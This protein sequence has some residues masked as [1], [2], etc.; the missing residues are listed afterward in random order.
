MEKDI[1]KLNYEIE[2]EMWWFK[3]RKNIIEKLFVNNILPSKPQ[4]L[5][6]FGAGS[7]LIS[8]M[9][10][11]YTKVTAVDK[12]EETQKYNHF[13]ISLADLSDFPAAH[14]DVIT[15]FDSLEHCENDKDILK[16]FYRI[17]KPGG[18]VL[19][20]VPAF[21]SLWSYHDEIHHHF[22]RY[23]RNEIIN[24]FKE[25]SIVPLK[26]SYFNFFLFPVFV[27]G[28]LVTRLIRILSGKPMDTTNKTSFIN[29]IL[30]SIFNIEAKILAKCS[31]PWGSSLLFI[32]KKI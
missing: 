13:P 25:H 26:S 8:S 22:R 20:T 21:Q 6:D 31:L 15:A 1:Y 16:E 9:L 23:N 30:Y 4:N 29:S 5:L 32:G 28:V 2:Q 11:K 12:F 18:F 19:I 14:F 27:V 24:K 17:L 7:G 3:A 10:S